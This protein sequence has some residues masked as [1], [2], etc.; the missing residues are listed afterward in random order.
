MV[1][2]WLEQPLYGGYPMLPCRRPRAGVIQNPANFGFIEGLGQQVVS[3]QVKHFGPETR[4]RL[5]IGDNYLAIIRTFADKVQDILPLA[6]RQGGFRENDLV[7]LMMKAVTGLEQ[8]RH[9]LQLERKRMQHFCETAG[10]FPA[11]R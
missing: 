3:A 8:R 5:A 1:S 11:A 10:V 2:P 7:F 9:V 6:V 4:I